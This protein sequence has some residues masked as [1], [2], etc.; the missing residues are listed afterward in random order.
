MLENPDDVLICIPEVDF[1]YLKQ[2]AEK[3]N[4]PQNESEENTKEAK[5]CE[6]DL[7]DNKKESGTI[8]I[9]STSSETSHE[10]GSLQVRNVL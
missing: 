10:R 6:E 2:I 3:S 1:T 8:D 9:P 7:G 5:T 4:I